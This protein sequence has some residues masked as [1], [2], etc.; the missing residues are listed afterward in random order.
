MTNPVAITDTHRYH[1]DDMH[2]IEPLLDIATDLC[3]NLAAEDRYQRLLAAVRRVVPCDAS[4]LLRLDGGGLVPVAVDGI[5]AEVLGRRF[6]AADHPRLDAL[7]RAE[8]PIRF[9][10]SRM[11]DPFDG[12]LMS[13]SDLAEVHACIGCPLRV[14]GK[15]IGVLTAD[16]LDPRAFDEVDDK[17]LAMFAGLAGAAMRTARLI[18]AL[19][20]TAAHQGLVARHLSRDARQRGG[21][22]LGASEA[23]RQLRHEVAMVGPSDLT[24]LITGETGVG[25]EVVA[26]ALHHA[27]PRRDAPMIHVNCAALPESVAESELFGHVRGAFTGAVE[28]R[29]GKFEVADGGTLFLDEVGE[30]PPALQP[31]L[32][33]AL[34]GGEIQRVGADRTLRVDVRVLAATNRDLAAEVRAGRFRADLY[35]RL[36]VYPLHVPPL[37]GHREDVPLLAG[38]F[39]DAAGLRLGV[40]H[41]RLGTAAAAALVAYDW[42]GNVREL[43]HL[44][45]RAALRAGRQD[46]TVIEPAHLSLTGTAEFTSAALGAGSRSAPRTALPLRD[47]VD[48]YTRRLIQQTLEESSGS[49]AEAAR[50]LG[51]PRANLHRV[52][53]RLGLKGRERGG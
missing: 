13:G 47:A 17:A 31:K 37:R 18:E 25:K 46:A 7:L 29:A 45:L 19:E 3:G 28:H 35:H 14:E 48:E 12:L 22:I 38:Y 49:W 26:H 15:V 2:S 20:G 9:A 36:S 53:V 11:P 1:S 41:L 5:R 24:V 39:L 23:I 44:L 52:G 51:T 34:Q 10:G 8:G 33:R 42:P 43:E 40:R 27:S 4:A 16:A 30:L 21:E 32:L 50:R 6:L